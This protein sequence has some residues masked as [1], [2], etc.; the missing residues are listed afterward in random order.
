MPYISSINKIMTYST[1]LAPWATREKCSRD[2]VWIT[3]LK[4]GSEKLVLER[5]EAADLYMAIGDRA[6]TPECNVEWYR[7]LSRTILRFDPRKLNPTRNARRWYLL[8]TITLELQL[9]TSQVPYRRAT[10]VSFH[11]AFFLELARTTSIRPASTEGVNAFNGHWSGLSH[12]HDQEPF[13]GSVI[14]A[15]AGYD[16]DCSINVHLLYHSFYWW[17]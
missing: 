1:E 9:V 4:W 3:D 7:Q 8:A 2:V 6:P 12:E 17:I 11:R 14:A 15:C 13:Q 5:G 16:F 10:L